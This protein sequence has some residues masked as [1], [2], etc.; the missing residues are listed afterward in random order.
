MNNLNHLAIGLKGES[1]ASQFLIE[2]GYEILKTRWTYKH[3]EID[4]IAKHGN[5]L[6]VV[7]VKTRT[8]NQYSQPEEAVDI[9]KQHFLSE[10]VEAFIQEYNDFDEIRFDIIAIILKQKEYTIYH[11]ENAFE[12]I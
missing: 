4:I 3:K 5:I 8:N 12:P 7:E 11:I 9:K 2:K 10:A 1:I 6:V